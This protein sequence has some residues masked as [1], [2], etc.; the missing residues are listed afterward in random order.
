MEEVERF[1]DISIDDLAEGLNINCELLDPQSDLSLSCRTP[2]GFA[3][4][5][6]ALVQ[7]HTP[8][9]ANLVPPGPYQLGSSLR[10]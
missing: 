4:I 6:R 10:D 3:E 9:R 2:G 5:R 1:D 8:R 7:P